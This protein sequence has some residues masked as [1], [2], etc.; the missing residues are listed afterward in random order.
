MIYRVFETLT[1]F[2]E[3]KKVLSPHLPTVIDAALRISSTN[4]F[5]LNLR[6][7]TMHFL[8]QIAENYS[9]YLVKK[10]GVAFID[11]IIDTGFAIASESEEDYEDE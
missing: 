5:S 8:E 6:E 4:G 10:A 3:F 1:D 11:N 9:R 2:V 7:I